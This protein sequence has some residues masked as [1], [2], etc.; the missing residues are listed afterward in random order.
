M[1]N[2]ID[3]HCIPKCYSVPIGVYKYKLESLHFTIHPSI[4][5]NFYLISPCMFCIFNQSEGEFNI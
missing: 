4:K 1:S 3:S 5:D 2:V